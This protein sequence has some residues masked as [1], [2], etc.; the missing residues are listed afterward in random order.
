MSVQEQIKEFEKEISTTKYNKKTQ[1]HIG[2]VKAKI[3]RLRQK[4]A[5]GSK[6]KGEGYSVR[7]T[8]DGTVILLG[9]PSVG[10]S[11]LLNA[12]T[13]AKSAIGA[14]DFTTLDVIPGLLNYN[15][16][17]IQ[18]LD[19]PGIVRGAADGTGRGREVLA[20][21]RSADLAVVIV[22]VNKPE[23]H[24]A[25]MKEVHDSG[26]RLNQKMPDVK[27]TKKARGGIRIGAT[28]PL[29]KMAK[30]TIETVARE[31]G[32]INA[33]VV[34][35]E[36]IDED[37]LIDVIEANRHYIPAIVVINKI[38]TVPEEELEKVVER[39]KPDLCISATGMDYIEKLKE[40]IF[41][42]LGLIRIYLK[43]IGKE[44]DLVEPL[45]MFKDC[46]V[47]NVCNKLHR[48]FV[49]KFRFARVWGS[50]KFPGQRQMLKYKLKDKDILEIHI[51]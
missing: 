48:D 29:T 23:E 15:F 5:G 20:V 1:H 40:L 42:K 9:F 31:M 11:T 44:A 30:N 19:V 13:G 47:E 24:N 26:I 17:K 14:Y 35:R 37:Q 49:R 36:D 32:I 2:L 51:S 28:I 43:E 6:K 46:T 33:D 45:I 21:M 25:I 16:A 22:D 4:L 34:I 18:V 10:K 41:E 12:L 38:D 8:G 50:S 3:A 39:I 7:K 27:I